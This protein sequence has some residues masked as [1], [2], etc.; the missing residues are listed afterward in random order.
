MNIL[1]RRLSHGFRCDFCDKSTR[2]ELIRHR[3]KPSRQT[4]SDEQNHSEQHGCSLSNESGPDLLH[5]AAVGHVETAGSGLPEANEAAV[6]SERCRTLAAWLVAQS[7]LFTES[8]SVS[9]GLRKSDVDG[10]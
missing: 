2:R 10:A 6:I 7:V 9:I 8:L 1:T 3:R 4:Q 5:I